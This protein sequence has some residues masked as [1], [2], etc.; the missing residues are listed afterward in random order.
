VG[1][2]ALAS[3]SS[4]CVPDLE[5][6]VLFRIL[7][8]LEI[9]HDDDWQ[10]VGAPK[11]RALLAALLILPEVVPAERLVDELW[12]DHPPAGAR[13]LVSGYVSQLRRLIGDPRGQIL[14]T[15]PLG[16]Q[17]LVPRN[18][19]DAGRFEELLAR[20][21]TMMENGHADPAAD[22]AA[23]GLALWRGRALAD[24][25]RGPLVTAE[26]ERLEELRLAAVELRIDASCDKD[27]RQS[28]HR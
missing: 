18:G 1:K 25:P 14:V 8:P 15:R 4:V 5:R 3:L 2:H 21:R 27:G 23:R 7:G 9:G 24:V 6:G 17:M 11:W 26:A 16:Y 20:A 22:A 13:K 19:V 10:G 28:S 12:L